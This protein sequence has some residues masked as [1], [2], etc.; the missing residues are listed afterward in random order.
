MQKFEER[1]LTRQEKD[2]PKLIDTNL[3]DCIPQT[4][5]C[6]NGCSNC[7]YN[8]GFYRPLDESLI[9]TIEEASGKI[10][11]VNSGHDSNLIKAKVL[12]DTKKYKDK[13]YNTSI[14]NFDFPAPVVWTCNPKDDEAILIEPPT[15]V[16]F[17]RFRTSMWNLSLLE[18]VID[19]YKGFYIMLTLMRYQARYSIPPKFQPMYEM[20]KSVVNH[21]YQPK[22]KYVQRI[23][24][25]FVEKKGALMCGTPKSHL[26]K[27]CLH[28]ETLYWKNLQA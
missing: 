6:P 15:N 24:D 11:R 4:G 8:E 22:E 16:M 25:E 21:Y 14:P 3:I 26:C 12:I 17:I 1:S 13:F 10:V 9:P 19:A 7:F 23:W 18:M 5:A 27:D 2:N 28:C 20:S